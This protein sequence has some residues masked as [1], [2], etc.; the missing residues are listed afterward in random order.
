MGMQ[1]EINDQTHYVQDTSLGCPAAKFMH[2]LYT[3]SGQGNT[4]DYLY[5]VIF[6]PENPQIK[7]SW[8]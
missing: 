1:I 2:G 5:S 3:S 4:R 7:P 6:N 8:S